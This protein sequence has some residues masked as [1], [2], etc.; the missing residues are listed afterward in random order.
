MFLSDNQ[1][2]EEKKKHEAPTFIP[3]NWKEQGDKALQEPY[4]TKWAC[5]VGELFCHISLQGAADFAIPEWEPR[6]QEYF[7]V[8]LT[9]VPF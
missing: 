2:P 1:D 6:T 5:F 7:I 3:P 9:A 4:Q 8:F